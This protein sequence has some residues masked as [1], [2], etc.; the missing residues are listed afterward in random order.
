MGERGFLNVEDNDT[1]PFLT[2]LNA[3]SLRILYNRHEVQ[4]GSR[5]VE[6][7]DYRLDLS[8]Y[9]VAMVR[10]RIYLMCF[11]TT[12]VPRYLFATTPPIKLLHQP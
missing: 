9:T 2:R 3:I 8:Y 6:A 10:R 12:Y 7:F 4:V 11:S 5:Q 1:H